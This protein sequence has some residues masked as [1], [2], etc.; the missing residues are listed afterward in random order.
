MSIRR[1]IGISESLH[2]FGPHSGWTSYFFVGRFGEEHFVT[3]AIRFL[4]FL[5][6]LTFYLSIRFYINPASSFTAWDIRFLVL[7]MGILLLLLFRRQITP[8]T[9][10]FCAVT[11][12]LSQALFYTVMAFIRIK[13]HQKTIEVFSSDK[14]A[15]DL[16][17]IKYIIYSFIVSALIVIGYN[18]FSSVNELNVY[19]NLYFLVVVY[20]TAC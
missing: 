12:I 5:V 10:Q 17:W 1:P 19:V 14:T 11:L 9:F 18:V 7:P 8:D 3:L 20:L 6:P 13:Q 15:I 4:Q 16:R 2:C